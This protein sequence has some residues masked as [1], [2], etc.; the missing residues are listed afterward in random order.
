M[1]YWQSNLNNVH[2]FQAH[3]EPVRCSRWDRTCPCNVAVVLIACCACAG[4][5]YSKCFLPLP[6]KCQVNLIAP[7]IC[8]YVVVSIIAV[9]KLLMTR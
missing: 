1:K 9:C 4:N 7:I 5:K 8:L 2:T 3:N 6:V